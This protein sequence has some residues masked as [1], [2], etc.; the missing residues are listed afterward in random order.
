VLA[1]EIEGFA[2]PGAAEDRQEL[3]GA[4]VALVLAQPATVA[5]LLLILAAGDAVQ[6]QPAAGVTLEGHRLLGGERR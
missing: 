2:A 5:A 6:Q 3:V 4:R 1:V